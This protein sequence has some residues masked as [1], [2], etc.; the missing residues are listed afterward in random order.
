MQVYKAPLEEKK[1][2]P[3]FVMMHGCGLSAMSWAL[4]AGELK[5]DYNVLA[6]DFRGHGNSR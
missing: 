1:D 2:G 6:F 3:T 4:V 5:K